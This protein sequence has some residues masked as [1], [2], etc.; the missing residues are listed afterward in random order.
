M[1]TRRR[2]L[3][4][5]LPLGLAGCTTHDAFRIATS[6]ARGQSVEGALTS[7]AKSKATGWVTNP[8]G[9]V[10]DIKK[11]SQLI[12]SVWGED[13]AL[14]PTPTTYVKYTDKY[15]SRGIVDF[16]KGQIRVETLDQS[17]LQSA[18]VTLLLSPEDPTQVDLYSDAPVTLGGEPFLYQQ[19]LDHEGQPVRWGWRAERY[20][21]YLLANSLQ[22]RQVKTANGVTKTEYFVELPLVEKHRLKRR[23][24][25]ATLVDK[26]SRQYN[27][28][29]S[30]VYAII[31]TESHFNPFA[32]SHAPAYGL[33]QIVPTTAG[34][35]AHQE[36]YGRAGTPSRN[37][38]FN[39]EN[40]IR[41][42]CAYLHILQTR[43]LVEVRDPQ[44]KE[45]CI[46]AA[47][48]GGV[49]NVLRSFSSDRRQAIS[50]INRS[51]SSSVWQRLQSRMP[52]ETQRYLV[53][54][55]DA[56]RRYV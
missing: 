23:Y 33:M 48:N 1:L 56:K 22:K 3:L 40:N 26:Y 34:R 16:E 30:L 51:S 29:P 47:Y 14:Q 2:F 15:L 27:I 7:H 8:K 39:V 13:E 28:N 32:V 41:M 49:G 20:A 50:A 55:T 25:Y 44:S 45:F 35:D 38:L 52:L 17:K 21:K 53:K 36:I 24:R 18:I 31:E 10:N 43:Y 46:I 6:V 54:V 37:Y 42:G 19:I 5:L 9:L 4:G 12:S 11:F